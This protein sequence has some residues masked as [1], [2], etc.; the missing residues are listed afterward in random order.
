MIFEPKLISAEAEL[1]LCCSRVHLD[2]KIRD[3]AG[4]LLRQQLDWEYLARTAYDNAVLPLFYSNLRKHFPNAIS[5]PTLHPLRIRFRD[6]V[7]H[8][9]LLTAELLKLLG[10]FET[11]GIR[12]VPFK[13]PVLAAMAYGDLS[14][15]QF[16]DL[17]ILVRREDVEHARSIILSR[18]FKPWGKS[19]DVPDA[20]YLRSRH[21]DTYVTEDGSVTIDLHWRFVQ[22]EYSVE[23]EPEH[24]WK[25]LEPISLGGRTI[26]C[27]KCDDLFLYLCIHGSKHCWER[28]GWI[29][30]ISEIVR[31]WP[32]LDWN[33]LLR[34]ANALNI[35]RV[36]L[37]ALKLAQD[38]LDTPLPEGVATR[39]DKD[40]ALEKLSHL[41]LK[42]L[43]TQ[44]SQSPI[45]LATT[46]FQF[47]IR[48]RLQDRLP[49]LMYSLHMAVTPNEHDL[50]LLRLP[51]FLYFL[52]YPLRTLRLATAYAFSRR[53]R[54]RGS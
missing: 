47:R 22:S 50:K 54:Y 53:E 18:G 3:R 39:I 7:K 9:F 6:H 16:S 32:Q 13:G 2:A 27:L 41:V 51:G 52:Y 17:D 23:F 4:S 28:L 29:C 31:A 1:L 20:V 45:S 25:R 34:R 12:A 26:P 36:V 21:A 46:S 44:Q 5:Q 43:F 37:L 11:R 42:K 48:T 40:P 38:L 35:E 30:D 10:E 14:L 49:Y 19:T 24:L 8:N 15:R 33:S